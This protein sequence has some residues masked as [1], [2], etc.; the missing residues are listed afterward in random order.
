MSIAG[1]RSNRGDRYQTLVAMDWALTVITDA[2]FDW[3]EIDSTAYSVDDVVIGKTAQRS[4]NSRSNTKSSE[5]LLLKM[6]STSCN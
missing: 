5:F 1:I 2:N 6:R 4:Q 3:I